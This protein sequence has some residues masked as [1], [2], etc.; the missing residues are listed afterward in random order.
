MESINERLQ[1]IIDKYFNGNVSSLEKA[2]NLKP[3]TLKNIIGGRLSNPSCETL[4][5]IARSV[6]HLHIEPMWIITGDGEMIK[7]T[8]EHT[9]DINNTEM[10][11]TTLI[12]VINNQNKLIQRLEREN[13]ELRTQ[14]EVKEKVTA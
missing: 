12:E 8:E 11:N 4:G 1:L 3:S 10:K 2:S 7:N 6:V 5:R 13:T 14:L 9:L